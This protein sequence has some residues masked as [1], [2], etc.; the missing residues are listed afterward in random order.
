MKNE[1]LESLIAVFIENLGLGI[2]VKM[3]SR[4]TGGL[5]NK[6]YRVET[7]KSVYAVKL[8]NPK[9]MEREDAYS[10][11]LFA[12]KVAKTAFENDVNAIHAL[13]FGGKSVQE[14]HG[15]FFLVYKWCD[16]K[17][18]PRN[19]IT[20]INCEKVGKTLA[21]IHDIDFSFMIDYGNYEN[22]ILSIDWENFL[23][24][25]KEQKVDWLELF[26]TNIENFN[27]WQKVANKAYS[28]LKYL[29]VCHNDMDIKNIMW[30]EDE[31]FIIDWESASIS[32]PYIEFAE[33][34]FCW[35]LD[36]SYKM[37]K[38]KVKAFCS[39]CF[40]NRKIDI[41]EFRKTSCKKSF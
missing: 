29:S 25:A 19:E 36:S 2:V 20:I 27:K 28:K 41:N 8:L 3:P 15:K 1:T 6:L 24:K 13:E 38:D 31:P 16:G 37:N 26:E 33:Y 5:I 39:A 40:T 7:L 11:H 10:N 18:I 21:K 9:V 23:N 22:S 17:V 4:V 12:E 32:F 14:F 30:V 35:S 34:S